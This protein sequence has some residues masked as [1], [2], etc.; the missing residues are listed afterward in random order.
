M[1]ITAATTTAD[2]DGFL[3][4]AES[5]PIFDD[6]RRQSVFQQ[7]IPQAPLGIN[8]QKVPVVTTKPTAN[9][10]G[11]GGKKPA[12]AMGMDLLFIEPKKLAAIAVLSAEVV[13]A[14]PG[15]INGQLR[16]YL[17]EAFAIA[18]D[19]AVGYDL[20]GDGTGTSPFDNPLSATTKSVELGTTTQAN[21][22]IHGD[23][24][25]GMKLLVDDGKKLTGFALDDVLEP[26][27]WG[28]VDTTGRPLYTELPTDET[29]QTIARPGRLLNR[30]SFM[31]E[32]VG[33]GATRAFGGN[34]RKA[35]WGVVGGISYR[36]S[37]EATVTING[38]LTSL[39]E[40]NLVAVLAEAEYGYVNSDVQSFVKYV[41]AV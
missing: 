17:A 15:N 27:L 9:W 25:A 12:T 37:T 35:A 16:P 40:N 32:G 33:H 28:A 24:V 34:F 41:D 18:F 38:A 19:L 22:G 1:A 14:N 11:E 2:F 8:G 10:V 29:S 13:R 3:T 31:G 36:V 21:G 5:A 23:L 6:A 30:P 4:P 7:L 20:G 26:T 39:W